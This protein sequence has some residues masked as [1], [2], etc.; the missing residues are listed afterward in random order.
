[1]T[2]PDETL[3]AIDAAID[4]W[5]GYDGAVSPDAMRW[6]PLPADH[7]TTRELSIALTAEQ[8]EAF[9][10]FAERVKRH[11]EVML[12]AAQRAAKGLLQVVARA[13]AATAPITYGDDYRKHRRSCRACNPAGNPRS[14][15]VNGADYT[16]RRKN[17]RHRGR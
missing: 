2:D 6:A 14:L 5:T 3:S 8:V 9:R 16:R 13:H 17:R 7:T 4:G 12:R 1:M 10:H 11:H 15:K